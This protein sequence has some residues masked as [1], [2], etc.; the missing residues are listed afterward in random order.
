MHAP[1]DRARGLVRSVDASRRAL[2]STWVS[3]PAPRLTRAPTRH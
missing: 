1:M 3:S 2:P